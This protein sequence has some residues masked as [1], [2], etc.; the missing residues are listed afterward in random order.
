L[1]TTSSHTP[2]EGT[3]EA[4]V[5][6]ISIIDKNHSKKTFLILKVRRTDIDGMKLCSLELDVAAL[7]GKIIKN[8]MLHFVFWI[9]QLSEK[10]IF[11]VRIYVT[12]KPTFLKMLRTL[13][14]NM[15]VVLAL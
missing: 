14:V 1:V 9:S 5:Y 15:T 13:R 4:L 6:G 12:E 11:K 8:G 10:S 3:A 2:D 7:T